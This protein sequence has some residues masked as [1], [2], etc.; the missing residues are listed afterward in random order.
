MGH[1][2]IT[3]K[4]IEYYLRANG[5]NNINVESNILKHNLQIQYQIL[6]TNENLINLKK[7][8]YLIFQKLKKK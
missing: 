8:S 7:K 3:P 6:N 1:N 4:L 5:Y 2:V